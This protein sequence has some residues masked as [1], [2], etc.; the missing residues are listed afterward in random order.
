MANEC[1][2]CKIVNGE[3]DAVKIWEDDEFLSILDLFPDT[4]GKALVLT[5]KHYDSD[6]FELPDDV[7]Q[8]MLSATRKIAKYLEKGLKAKRVVMVAEGLEVNHVHIKLMP[9]YGSPLPFRLGPKVERSELERIAEEIKKK[10]N[11]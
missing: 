5:K 2:F 8:R 9:F 3:I 7:Y 1:I 4:K 11:L 10:N 6:L